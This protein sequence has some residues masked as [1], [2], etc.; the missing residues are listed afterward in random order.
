MPENTVKRPHV[1]TLDNRSLL[2]L[3]GVEDVAGFDEN[4]ISIRTADCTLIVKGT[5][6][7]ISKLSL[8]T[9]DV[10]IDGTISSLQYMGAA[11]SFRSRLFK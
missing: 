7:H 3:S 10:I 6:L 4:T 5:S 2:T 11:K 9:G 1:L 8:D